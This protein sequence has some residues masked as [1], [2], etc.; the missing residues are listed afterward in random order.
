MRVRGEKTVARELVMVVV[1]TVPR[2][3]VG[4]LLCSADAAGVEVV[5][6]AALVRTDSPTA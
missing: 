2:K 3:D 4:S 6:W 1:Q 5:R